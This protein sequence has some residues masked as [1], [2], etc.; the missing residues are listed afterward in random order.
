MKAER[1]F[2]D[3]ATFGDGFIVEM[4]IWRVPM[5]LPPSTHNLKYSLFYGREGERVVAYDNERGKG[6]HRYVRG[7]ESKYH[8]VSAE[9]L[10]E[11]FLT[12]VARARDKP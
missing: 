3:K 7:Q 5:P 10:I 12:E 8:F 6:D 11:D 4:V 9:Q 1:L 2:S